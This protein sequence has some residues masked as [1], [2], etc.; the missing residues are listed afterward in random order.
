MS[1]QMGEE[2]Y[3]PMVEGLYEDEEWLTMKCGGASFRMDRE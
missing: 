2:E 3:F 1:A